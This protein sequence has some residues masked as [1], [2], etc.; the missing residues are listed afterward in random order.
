LGKVANARD[1]PNTSINRQLIAAAEGW[2]V[3]SHSAIG[4]EPCA[5]EDVPSATSTVR[6]FRGVWVGPTLLAN[7]VIVEQTALDAIEELP[8]SARDRSASR[9]AL[10]AHTVTVVGY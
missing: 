6:S 10:C 9:M 5:E 1:G 3:L 8:T 4:A 7:Q 2:G